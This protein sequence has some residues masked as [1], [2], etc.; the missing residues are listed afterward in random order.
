MCIKSYT[1]KGEVI[2]PSWTWVSTTNAVL[3]T[4]N[5]PVFADV[6]VNSRN[7][8]AEE[9]K[10]KISKK[11]IAVIAVHFAGCHVKWGI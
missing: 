7:L 3:N 9:I 6:D 5:K 8:T 10:K 11:T 1:K 4:G 2:I